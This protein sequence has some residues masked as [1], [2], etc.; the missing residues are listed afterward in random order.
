MVS[1]QPKLKGYIYAFIATFALANVYIFS[2]A[3]MREID[4]GQFAFYWFGLA[5]IWNLLY[6]CWRKKFYI[7]RTITKRLYLVIAIVGVFE[8][9]GT[10]TFFNAIKIVENPANVSFMANMVPLFI[11]IIGTA[12]LN[13]RYNYIEVIGIIL[14]LGGTFLI[15]YK[16]NGDFSEMFMK[17]S[18]VIVIA[19]FCFAMGTIVSKKYIKEID[20]M[21]FSLNRVIYL[22]VLAV[23]YLIVNKQNLLIPNY[24]LFNIAIGSLLGPF[25]TA[26]A[27]YTSLIYIEA[28]RSSIIQST[29]GLFVVVGAIIY[30]GLMP[31]FNEIAGGIISIVGVILISLGKPALARIKRRII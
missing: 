14:T 18:G 24:A 12:F 19:S 23:I 15:S 22:F 20:P 3:A 9:V 7:F 10:S 21:L 6:I 31:V 4:F 16:G 25:L 30:F 2:K 17:G 1:I 27:V 29:K 13:E 8:V 5:I 26:M 28:S 11:T